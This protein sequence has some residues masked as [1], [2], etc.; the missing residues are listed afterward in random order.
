MPEV[1]A[2]LVDELDVGLRVV[3]PPQLL[4]LGAHAP[5]RRVVHLRRWDSYIYPYMY[6]CIYVYI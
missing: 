6:V 5:D 2:R 1:A 4:E 3:Q